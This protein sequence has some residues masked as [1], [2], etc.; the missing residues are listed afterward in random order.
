MLSWNYEINSERRL[1]GQ[2]E[3]S[4]MHESPP[5]NSKLKTHHSSLNT[6][7]SPLGHH[8][9]HQRIMLLGGEALELLYGEEEPAL[10]AAPAG[11]LQQAI[12]IARP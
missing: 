1:G 12:V 7:H 6:Q 11:A 2:I 4:P 9:I 3:S 8:R 5:I 10:E